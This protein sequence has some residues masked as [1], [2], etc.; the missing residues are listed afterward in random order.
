MAAPADEQEDRPIP[1]KPNRNQGLGL[2]RR[3]RVPDVVAW[4]RSQFRQ[5]CISYLMETR[6]LIVGKRR[7]VQ[8]HVQR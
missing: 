6:P 8:R 7:V 4:D 1:Q 2:Q 3:G 5:G